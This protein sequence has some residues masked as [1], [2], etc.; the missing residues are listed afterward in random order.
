MIWFLK[1]EGAISLG[2]FL[3]SL[4]LFV[5]GM[6]SWDDFLH[7]LWGSGKDYRSGAE[8]WR[9]RHPGYGREQGGV[10]WV[11]E[12]CTRWGMGTQGFIKSVS[13]LFI[14]RGLAL[15]NSP[16]F[17]FNTY[18]CNIIVWHWLEAWIWLNMDNSNITFINILLAYFL[19]M[20]DSWF[21]VIFVYTF[22]YAAFMQDIICWWMDDRVQWR[23]C[24]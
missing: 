7:R 22:N 14:I 3:H 16:S 18:N 20:C 8:D 2:I 6:W 12:G 13:T 4:F 9:Q 5:S 17:L 23:G 19:L 1:E 21:S 15:H 11:S 10:Y 24:Q